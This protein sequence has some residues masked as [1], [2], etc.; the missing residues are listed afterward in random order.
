MCPVCLCRWKTKK[1]VI[2]L[3][4]FR[5]Y[6][7][8]I[9]AYSGQFGCTKCPGVDL[10]LVKGLED[11]LELNLPLHLFRLSGL[12]FALVFSQ[13]LKENWEEIQDHTNRH[14]VAVVHGI[15]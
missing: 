7:L 14:G 10:A 3:F 5:R 6:G 9:F 4:L 11:H 1:V 2:L 13:D 15:H 8:R 12:F